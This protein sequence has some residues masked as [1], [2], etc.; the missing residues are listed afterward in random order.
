MSGN[1]LV[2]IIIPTYNVEWFL[3]ETLASVQQQSFREFEAIVVDDGSTDRTGE[4][5]QRFAEK[6]GR[7]ILLRQKNAGVSAARNAAF[8][9]AR[10]RL[11]AFLDADDVWSPEKLERQLALFREDP[12]VNFTFTNLFI[13]DGR[14][15]LRLC[16][17]K[18]KP[19]PEGNPIRQLIFDNL[20]GI[21]TV[22]VKRETLDAAGPFDSELSMAEDWDMWLRMADRDLWAR[23]IREPLSRYRIWEGNVSKQRLRIVEAVVLMLG[24]NLHATSRPELR[25]LYERS[26]VRVRVKLELAKICPQLDTHPELVPDAIW[27]AWKLD[28]LQVKW[29]FRW[30]LVV[31][32]HF[33][34]GKF[35]AGSVYRKLREKCQDRD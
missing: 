9:R 13:W 11:I 32:P 29:L 20:F 23:G 15:D 2:S 19:L 33:L 8:K 7:F 31:W 22:M 21:S 17:R 25:P 34:G 16:Y 10:G 26:L 14:R 35:T 3:A 24:K 4:I 5:A 12:R 18:H 28:P 1:P 27:R 6:D 30:A